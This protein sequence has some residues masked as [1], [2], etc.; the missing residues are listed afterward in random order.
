MFSQLN[1]YL[2][3]DLLMFSQLNYYLILDLL[4]FS[5]LNYYLIFDF[6]VSSQLNNYLIFSFV[7]YYLPY[8]PDK[9][10]RVLDLYNREFTGQC[11][12]CR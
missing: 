2:I 10:K 6:L 8:L 9:D 4:V 3:L 11:R 7:S 1:Y 12:W 5:Q